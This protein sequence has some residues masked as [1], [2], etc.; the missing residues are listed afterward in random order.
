MYGIVATEFYEN[1]MRLWQTAL[2]NLAC[3]QFNS[4]KWKL[5]FYILCT[6]SGY[7][8]YFDDLS[9]FLSEQ[10]F[11]SRISVQGKEDRGVTGNFEITLE[12]GRV[13]HSKRIA[14]QGK[15]QTPAERNAIAE[16]IKEYLDDLDA[17]DG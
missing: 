13:I 6:Y 1:I 9:R 17:E 15:A 5:K 11:G 7:R 4:N 10:P 8:R 16:Q 14:G 2:I 3:C 12:D